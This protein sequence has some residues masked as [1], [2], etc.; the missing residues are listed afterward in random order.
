MQHFWPC[1][2]AKTKMTSVYCQSVS[3]GLNGLSFNSNVFGAEDKTRRLPVT[4]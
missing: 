3:L 1:W 2:V 4:S